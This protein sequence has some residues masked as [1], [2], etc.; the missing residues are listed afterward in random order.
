MS[1]VNLMIV[2]TN[3]EF[4]FFKYFDFFNGGFGDLENHRSIKNLEKA[5]KTLYFT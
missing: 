3:L 5:G 4:Q 2:K 1:K